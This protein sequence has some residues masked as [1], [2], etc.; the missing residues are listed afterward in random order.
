RGVAV[1]SNDN[2]IVVGYDNSPGNAQWRIMKFDSNLNSLRNYTVNPSSSYDYA[3]A[4]VNKTNDEIIVVGMDRNATSTQWRIMKFNSSLDSIRNYTTNDSAGVD[5]ARGVAVDSNDNIIVVGYDNSPGNAQWRIMKFDSNL[6]SLKNYT[7]NNPDNTGSDI[8]WDVAVDS[9]DNI[10][11]VGYDNSPGN[12]QWRIMKFNSSL[13]STWNY[14]TNDSPYADMARGV[15]VDSNDSIIVVGYDNVTTSYEW[16]IMKFV[17]CDY[18]STICSICGYN[19]TGTECCEPN[20]NYV[21]ILPYDNQLCVAGSNKT[22]ESLTSCDVWNIGSLYFCN[23]TD[24]KWHPGSGTDHQCNVSDWNSCPSP[25]QRKRDILNCS[26]NLGELGDCNL[27]SGDDIQ[28]CGAGNNCSG[29]GVCGPGLCDFTYRCSLGI[30]DNYYGVYGQYR[31][32]GTC[33]VNG[34]CEN[35]TNCDLCTNY[36]QYCENGVCTSGTLMID[37]IEIKPIDFPP[38]NVNP[39]A[40]GNVR[41]NVTVNITNSTHMDPNNPCTVRIFNATGSYSNPTLGPWLGTIQKVGTQWQCFQGWEMEY[42]RNPGRWNVSVNL[43]LWTGVSNFTS[44]NFTYNSLYAWSDN[45][46]IINWTGLPGQTVNSSNSYPMLVNNTGNMELDIEIN[47]S[48]F[49]GQSNPSYVIG[50]KNASFSNTTPPSTF[51]SLTK[52][53]QFMISLGVREVKYIYFRAYLPVGFISQY[54]NN[55]IVMSSV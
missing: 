1:D 2:I 19:W 4:V 46:T 25:C 34:N 24:Y 43:S 51:Y 47:G 48:D 8:A 44:K 7:Y 20:D 14:T 53:P 9:N 42:W 27:D 11:V 12:Y 31:C 29:N 35:A 3:Y 38:D 21:E 52:T 49:I 13:D 28:P 10:I 55:N 18:N 32:Q 33:D 5:E 54:Y 45:V 36:D 40:G 23:N 16:R 37:S 41:M 22:C 26:G 50:I 15:A 39:I 30:G 17:S 6:N